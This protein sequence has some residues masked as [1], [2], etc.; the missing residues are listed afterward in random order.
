MLPEWFAENLAPPAPPPKSY[1]I[2]S[3]IRDKILSVSDLISELRPLRD[4]GSRIVFTN[5]CFDI[6][7]AGHID[8]I[9]HAR[10]LGDVLIVGVN[11]DASVKL[12][13][14]PLRPIIPDHFRADMLAALEAVDYVVL[15]DE[16]EAEPL[17][18]KVLP[19]ILV[20][21]GDWAH[22]VSGREVVEANGG[23]VVLANIVQGQST[24]SI[25]QKIQ[26][27]PPD[28]K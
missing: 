7:H 14:G 27:L 18:A 19:D 12:N 21:G 24:T 11:S 22:W 1:W 13:K 6:M 26:T 16:K 15:F 5:G 8:Y 20:K 3:M 17:I 25:I 10:S 2:A 23:K 4:S 28:S 9:W